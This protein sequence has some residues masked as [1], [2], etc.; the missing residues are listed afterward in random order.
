M[1]MIMPKNSSQITAVGGKGVGDG[2]P[3]DGDVRCCVNVEAWGTAVSD[4]V[5]VTLCAAEEPVNHELNHICLLSEGSL[6]NPVSNLC[7]D[8][9]AGTG[10]KPGDRLEFSPCNRSYAS[11][12]I[13]S[14]VDQ[15]LV[16]KSHS[17]GYIEND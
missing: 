12:W 17:G 2:C 7:A 9:A 10:A 15:T 14:P 5:W 11:S 16:Q 4:E 6:L 8:A 13:Y 1:N 3:I